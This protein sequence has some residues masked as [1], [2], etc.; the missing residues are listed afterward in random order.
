ME[1]SIESAKKYI[2]EIDF[3]SLINKMVLYLGWIRK[4]AEDTAHYYRNFLFLVKKGRH[5]HF[6]DAPETLKPIP[7]SYDV[8]EFWHMHIL[9]TRKYID[10]CNAI[11]GSYLHHYPYLGIDGKSTIEGSVEAFE[12]MQKTHFNEFGE[13]VPATRSRFHP[14]V[15]KVLKTLKHN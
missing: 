10:D 12:E 3:T 6:N 8:D 7:A 1:P 4:D 11:F 14:A 15:Y 5:G 13:I 9:D 2:E